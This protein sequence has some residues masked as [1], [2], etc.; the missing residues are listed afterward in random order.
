MAYR[1]AWLGP[2]LILLAGTAYQ[3]LVYSAV[4]GEH[5]D[6][7]RF[8]LAYVPL[9]VL[10]I[11]VA[12]RAHHKL[13]WAVL[14]AVAGIAI[15]ALG[16]QGH[17]GL[18]AAYAAPHAA[19]YLAFSRCLDARSAGTRADHAP[20]AGLHAAAVM[21]ATRRLTIAWCVFSARK[22]SF[23]AALLLHRSLTGRFS[24]CFKFSTAGPHVHRRIHIASFIAIS[25]SSFLDGVRAS[26]GMP[27][28][29]RRKCTGART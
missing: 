15:Y 26:P 14:L 24:S 28:T 25:A 11:W 22:S 8:A 23:R 29:V 3:W 1:C 7:I 19:I 6:S 2:A 10:T 20:R 18:A 12:G 21:A 9:L 13:R 16:H 5:A 4:A 17:W 27:T